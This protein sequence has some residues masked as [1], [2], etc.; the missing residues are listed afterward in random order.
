M[1]SLRVADSPP[2]DIQGLAKIFAAKT[3]NLAV[4]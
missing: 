2:G 4:D 3:P 1:K